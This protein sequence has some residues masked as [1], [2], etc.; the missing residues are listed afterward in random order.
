MLATAG[1]AAD[2]QVVPNLKEGTQEIVVGGYFDASS[3]DGETVQ[4]NGSYG[5]FIMDYLEVGAFASW[6]TTDVAGDAINVGAFAE[7]NFATETPVV[8]FVGIRAAYASL[9]LEDVELDDAF[10]G[11]ATA[12]VKYFLADNVA[13]KLALNGEMASED[14]YVDE[15][16][17]F[18]DTDF[19]VTLGMAFYLP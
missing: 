2:G 6:L 14:I 7:Y 16:M 15:D 4:L 12:G 13:L 11:I 17:Q 18:E 10:V 9:D 1:W 8:P 19:N 5:L 3:L